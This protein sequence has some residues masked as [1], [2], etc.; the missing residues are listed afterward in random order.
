MAKVWKLI[1]VITITSKWVVLVPKTSAK[2]LTVKKTLAEVRAPALL[3]FCNNAQS[4]ISKIDKQYF[5]LISMEVRKLIC[6][7]DVEIS[8]S[9][10]FEV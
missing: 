1:F 7:R 3:G 4:R 8:I 9:L 5:N 2:C 10:S 6:S